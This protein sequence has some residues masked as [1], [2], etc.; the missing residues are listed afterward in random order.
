MTNL[1]LDLTVQC[2]RSLAKRES[3]EAIFLALS[4][5]GL[6]PTTYGFTEPLKKKFDSSDLSGISALWGGDGAF[7]YF[8]LGKTGS[9]HLNTK[10]G[11]NIWSNGLKLQLDFLNARDRLPVLQNLL[12]ELF[13]ICGGDYAAI[14][15]SGGNPFSLDLNDPSKNIGEYD[16]VTIPSASPTGITS[17]NGIWWINVLGPAYVEFFG[18]EVLTQIKGEE[19]RFL[20]DGSFWLQVTREPQE[21]WSAGGKENILHTKEVLNRPRAF[22]GYDPSKPGIMLQYE[23]P[24]FDLHELRPI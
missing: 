10:K 13:E 20:G 15:L 5:A 17:L 19:A 6:I 12:Q 7:C 1:I 23:A 8:R 4:K 24:Q 22:Y 2:V 18:R 11:R 16:G 3:V 21:M 9:I 14:T